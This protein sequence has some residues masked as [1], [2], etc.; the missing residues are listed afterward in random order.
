MG[1]GD[2]ERYYSI[3]G[4]DEDLDRGSGLKRFQEAYESFSILFEHEWFRDLL[5]RRRR[6]RIV[7]VCGG[8]GI[9]GIAM[10]KLLLDRGFEYDL[11]VNDLRFSAL[12]KARIYSRAYLGREADVIRDDALNLYKHVREADIALIYGFST[13]HF[14]VYQMIH[15]IGGLS[16]V[17]GLEGVLVIEDYDRIWSLYQQRD[18]RDV[19]LESSKRGGYVL[20]GHIAYDP[21]RGVFKR[22]FIDLSTMDRVA[23][24]FRLWDLA[25]LLSISWFFFSEID[26]IET[27]SWYRGFILARRSRG[28]DPDQYLVKPKI[29]RSMRT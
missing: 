16:R 4:W 24:E 25:G 19:S 17:L 5:S 15:L 14:D 29:S 20:S 10:A 21:F 9:G 8:S 22:I 27:G 26:F 28:I 3:I 7:D 18:F 6:F 11:I 2:L 13:P 1:Y 23:L 12:E